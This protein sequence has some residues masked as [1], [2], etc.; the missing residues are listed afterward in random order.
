[1]DTNIREP[2]VK[3]AKLYQTQTTPAGTVGYF[4]EN[5]GVLL[6]EVHGEGVRAN[7]NRPIRFRWL[8]LDQ[9]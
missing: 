9:H 5:R 2:R 6:K 1:M 3:F 4:E 7:H 8:G